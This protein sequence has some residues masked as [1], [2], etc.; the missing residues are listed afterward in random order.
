MKY[1]PKSPHVI[2]ALETI[3]TIVNK[4]DLER[5]KLKSVP[6]ELT[7]K[8]ACF[9]S[10]HL[11]DG[12]LRGCIG[13]I[14]PRESNLF[15]EIISNSVFA[16]TRDT[17]FLPIKKSELEELEV[18]VDVLS[19]PFLVED[20]KTLDPEKFGVIVSDGQF[21]RG[22]LLPALEGVETVEKQIGIARKKA[23]LAHMDISDLL[24]YAFTSTR[25]Y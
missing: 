17:R 6:E 13:T 7:D 9:V 10:I 20:I 4:H 12:S 8:L 16:A 3:Q 2:L 1:K 23:G 5:I 14:D 24:I 18:S 19:K 22:V 25:F 11:F 21:S 15:F